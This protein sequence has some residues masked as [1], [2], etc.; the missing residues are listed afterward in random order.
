MSS[1]VSTV[2][3]EDSETISSFNYYKMLYKDKPPVYRLLVPMVGCCSIRYCVEAV[4]QVQQK[5]YMLSMVRS[6][7]V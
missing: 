7:E 2:S 3:A 6:L 5:R 4:L 1:S